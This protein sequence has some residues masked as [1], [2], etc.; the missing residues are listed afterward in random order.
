MKDRHAIIGDV[1]GV[2][3]IQGIEF[4]KDRETKEHFDPSVGVNAMLTEELKKRGVWIRV[5]AYILPIAPPLTIT[6][7]E[8]DNLTNIIDEAL[9]AVEYRLGV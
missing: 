2:G 1:R 4:V 6:A 9:G 5:P 7:D 8:T 3:L